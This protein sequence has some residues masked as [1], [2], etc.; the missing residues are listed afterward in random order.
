MIILGLIFFI[1]KSVF[2]SYN[3][4]LND[5][6]N[7]L[8]FSSNFRTLIAGGG[9]SGGVT[10]MAEQLNNTKSETVYVDFSIN[11]MRIAQRKAKMRENLKI[12]WVMSWIENIPLYGLGEFDLVN[13]PGVLHHLKSPQRGLNILNDIQSENGGG[14]ISVYGR[15]ARSGVYQIQD[16][17]THSIQRKMERTV[18]RQKIF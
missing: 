15:Y 11:S 6:F 2:G 16:L 14:V 8:Y 10:F 4:F 18:F 7:V 9:T 1:Q 12:I 5:I 3:I 17:L 13:C